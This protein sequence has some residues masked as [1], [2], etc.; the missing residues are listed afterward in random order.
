MDSILCILSDSVIFVTLHIGFLFL[1]IYAFFGARKMKR[2][3]VSVKRGKGSWKYFS[4]GYGI[5]SVIVTQ[6]ISVSEFWK[7]YKV[8]ITALDL[9]GLLYLAFFNSWFRNKIIGFVVASQ[10]KEE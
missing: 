4:L 1:V 6:I 3:Q 5:L 7:G 8:L 2:D 9:G 10:R